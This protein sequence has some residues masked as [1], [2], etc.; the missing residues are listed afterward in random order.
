M[1]RNNN[2]KSPPREVTNNELVAN[3]LGPLEGWLNSLADD[4]E[5]RALAAGW[6]LDQLE[7]MKDTVAV[8]RR[9]A[10]REL[11][12]NNLSLGEIAYALA[13]SRSRVD[14]LANQ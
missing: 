2:G 7:E 14:Q 10:V 12:A 4:P 1:S 3:A 6:L 5:A 8:H 11:R 9:A 13:I